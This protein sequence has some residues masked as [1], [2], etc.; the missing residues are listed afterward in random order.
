MTSRRP[1]APDSIVKRAGRPPSP[2][3]KRP[4][5]VRSCKHHGEV[6]FGNYS[7]GNGRFKWFCKKC[8]AENVTRRHQKV[9]RLLREEAGGCC[10]VCGYSRCHFN[11]HFHHV[12]PTKKLFAVNS[13]VGKSLARC[14][15]EAAKC[16]L[17]CANCHGEIE[18]GLIPSPPA[19]AKFG[20]VWA[21]IPTVD[22]HT[23]ARPEKA[24]HTA[25]EQTRL[26]SA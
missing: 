24:S 1:A 16:V 22:R 26:D 20:E 5:A 3:R 7:A 2:D 9:R 18:T 25:Y 13:G 21:P 14:R 15:A 19:G 23:E 10:A 11:L 6:E 8:I 17:V 4:V 12:D